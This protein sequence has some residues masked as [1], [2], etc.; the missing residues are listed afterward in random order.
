VVWGRGDAAECVDSG[1]AVAAGLAAEK[2]GADP[3]LDGCSW[4]IMLGVSISSTNLYRALLWW[5]SCPEG[6]CVR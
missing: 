5:A 1:T 4:L 3:G 2:R 6:K